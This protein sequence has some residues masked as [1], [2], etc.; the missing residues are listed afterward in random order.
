MGMNRKLRVVLLLDGYVVPAWVRLMLQRV[1]VADCAD[2]V[3]IALNES[4]G[5]PEESPVTKRLRYNWYRLPE[6]VVG[7]CLGFI[8]RM[9]ME[10][11]AVANHARSPVDVS[12]LLKDVPVL[13]VRPDTGQLV[14]RFNEADIDRLRAVDPDVIVRLGFRILGGD[15]LTV[16][17]QGVWSYHHGDNRVNRGGPPGYW[18]TMESWPDTGTVLQILDDDL[19]GG[20]VLYRSWS[21]T[22]RTSVTRNN[23]ARYW[24]SAS[25]LPRALA[26][27]HVL[28]PERFAAEIRKSNGDLQ[29][30]SEK[31]YSRPSNAELS[32][33]LWRKVLEKVRRRIRYTFYFDQW[34]LLYAFGADIPRTLRKYRPL[35][36]P[37][38]RFWADPFAVHRDGKYFIF[39]E[40]LVYSENVGRISMFTLDEEGR[41]GAA[42]PVIREGHHL[43]YPFLFET[44]GTLYMLAEAREVRAV[45]LYRCE[46]FPDQWVFEKNLMEDIDAVDPTL[47]CHEG[48]WYLF[49]NA[50]ENPGASEWDE[51]FVYSAEHPIDGSWEAH[52]LNPVVSDVKTAR[53]AGRLLLRNG[54]LYRPSQ[55]C[56]R[57]YGYALNLNR[58]IKLDR[59]EYQE[60]LTAKIVPHWD[61]RITAVHTLST[62]HRLTVMDAQMRRARYWSR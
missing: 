50:A 1:F 51:L 44:G 61:P 48:R 53:P 30:Y 18:E 43:S 56:S 45:P 2:V 54:E 25:F 33:L 20:A 62:A 17:R 6:A 12:D 46:R 9:L 27:L 24:S 60:E 58:I 47:H 14:D 8:Q 49:V 15:I 4:A 35:V 59:A 31:L 55:D 42:I 19:D 26:R 3:L 22:E 7:H 34:V 39:M 5:A 28:G 29:F 11:H 57:R 38:D 40:E 21:S 32:R 37:Q 16:A 52:P 36:P 10:R 23:N 41:Q 13:R